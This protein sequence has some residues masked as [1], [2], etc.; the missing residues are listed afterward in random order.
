MTEMTITRFRELADAFGGNLERWPEQER[1]AALALLS[2]TPD[3]SPVLHA[4]SELDALLDGFMNDAELHDTGFMRD[5]ILEQGG[6]FD[7]RGLLNSLWPFGGLWQPA[8]G[9]AV[10]SLA[11]FLVGVNIDDL[12]ATEASTAYTDQLTI[13]ERAL[14]ADALEIDQ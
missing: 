9:L 6:G 10:A 13:V 5:P 14:G 12:S 8:A 11:G 2:K 4:S 1:D 3:L 7:I